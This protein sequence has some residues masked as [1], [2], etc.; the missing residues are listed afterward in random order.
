MPLSLDDKV[1]K[2]K[3]GEKS[4]KK[5]KQKWVN[6]I[7]YK[8]FHQSQVYVGISLFDFLLR[9]KGLVLFVEQCFY[10]TLLI[11]KLIFATFCCIVS[12]LCDQIVSLQTKNAEHITHKKYNL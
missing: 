12:H 6:T 1:R 9:I 4:N 3:K 7:P 8:I 10:N 2:R 11:Y 5:Y